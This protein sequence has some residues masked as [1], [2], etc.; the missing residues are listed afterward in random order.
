[1]ARRGS[2]WVLIFAVPLALGA[3]GAAWSWFDADGPPG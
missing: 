3:G 2:G 1:M